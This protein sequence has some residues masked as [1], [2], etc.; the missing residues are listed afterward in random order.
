MVCREAEAARPATARVFPVWLVVCTRFV[1]ST[2]HDSNV[3]LS[4]L[5]CP[6]SAPLLELQLAD[7]QTNRLQDTAAL[8]SR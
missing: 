4:R 2:E 3:V 8:A 1:L 5:R 7:S 6:F